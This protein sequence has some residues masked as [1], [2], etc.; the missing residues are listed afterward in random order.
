MLSKHEYEARKRKRLH[1]LGTDDPQCPCGENRWQ[2]LELHHAEGQAYGNTLVIVCRNC[3]RILSVAQEGHPIHRSKT[4]R[5]LT[6][7]AR[8]L[9]GFADLLEL[10]VAKLRETATALQTHC[11]T[12]VEA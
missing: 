2:C 7:M 6:R 9:A 10:V 1:A 5:D 8:L 4:D 3:H 12:L 11:Q